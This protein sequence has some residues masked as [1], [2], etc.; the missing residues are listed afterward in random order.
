[1]YF[2][3]STL[4]LHAPDEQLTFKEVNDDLIT[5]IEPIVEGFPSP[6][7][8]KKFRQLNLCL[9]K[10]TPEKLRHF[11][12]YYK[13]KVVGTGTLFLTEDAFNI[14]QK[15]GFKIYATTAVYIKFE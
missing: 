14:Y 8:N 7:G 4:V 2:D 3:L 9:L 1:M 11:I 13:N 10:T 12:V 6:D 15:I 5:W